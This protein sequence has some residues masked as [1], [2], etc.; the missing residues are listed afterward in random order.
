MDVSKLFKTYPPREALMSLEAIV[1]D[2]RW[3]TAPGGHL[4]AKRDD[5]VTLT[6]EQKTFAHAVAKATASRRPNGKM[7]NHQTKVPAAIR[8]E[9][10]SRI[11]GVWAYDWQKFKSGPNRFDRWY[12]AIEEI[13][14][15]GIGP[16]TTYDV[17]VRIGAWIGIKPE[18][19]YLHAGVRAGWLALDGIPGTDQEYA[20]VHKPRFIRGAK[21]VRRHWWPAIFRDFEADDFEDFLCTYRGILRAPSLRRVG[22]DGN[23]PIG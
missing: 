19:L 11:V 21:R 7:H 4:E 22:V 15:R 20:L 17:A 18:S 3:R 12:D 5:V 10:A 1:R 6:A 16:V 13:R 2:W 9:F 23:S 8:M 14:P